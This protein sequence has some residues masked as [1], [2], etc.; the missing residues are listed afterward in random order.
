MLWRLCGRKQ[1]R[2]KKERRG[3]VHEESW[4]RGKI[5]HVYLNFTDPNQAHTQ[6]TQH[7]TYQGNLLNGTMWNS[8]FWFESC[9]STRCMR[10]VNVIHSMA[11]DDQ[12]CWFYFQGM[13]ASSF[14]Y[15][16]ID[17]VAGEREERGERKE[18]REERGKRRK[19]I[20]KKK[21]RR[22]RQWAKSKKKRRQQERKTTRVEL[23]SQKHFTLMQE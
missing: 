22:G 7:T 10:N 2:R 13:I 1:K 8:P 14:G 23:N 12:L 19:R 20:K 3:G 4:Y 21:K 5:W 11:G 15:C 9:T 17:V 6:H 18:R 16:T